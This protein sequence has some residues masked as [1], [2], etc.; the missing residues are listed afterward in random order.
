MVSHSSLLPVRPGGQAVKERLRGAGKRTRVGGGTLGGSDTCDVRHDVR[1][2]RPPAPPATLAA[3]PR[4]HTDSRTVVRHEE[5]DDSRHGVRH[6]VASG[7]GAH[8]QMMHR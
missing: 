7:G 5:S 8:A 1:R 3:A 6:T 4:R 2:A